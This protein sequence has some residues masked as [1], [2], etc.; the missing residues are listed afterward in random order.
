MGTEVQENF[1][2]L[3]RST[4]TSCYNFCYSNNFCVISLVIE[5]NYRKTYT[6]E[7]NNLRLM[8]ERER[9]H[10]HVQTI[11]KVLEKSISRFSGS[12]DE[13]ANSTFGQNF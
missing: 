6:G 10:D 3:I 11:L 7:S 9:A 12:I 2:R 5:H 13:Y 1:S 8:Q 4:L